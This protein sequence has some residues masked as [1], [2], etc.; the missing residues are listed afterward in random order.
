MKNAISGAA[1]FF[2]FAYLF[3]DSFKPHLRSA[4]PEVKSVYVSYQGA[5]QDAARF[6][7]LMTIALDAYGFRQAG[8]P[9]SAD[10]VIDISIN[11]AGEKEQYPVY[12][13]TLQAD[14]AL[15]GGRFYR[16]DSC[17]GIMPKVLD[18]GISVTSVAAHLKKDHPYLVRVF[19]GEAKSNENSDLLAIINQE[20]KDSGFEVV[21]EKAQAQ[22]VLK[23]VRS[24]R[25]ALYVA[26][27]RQTMALNMYSPTGL[28]DFG[29]RSSRPMLV[30]T[31]VTDKDP[32][33]SR[34]CSI[35]LDSYMERM[36]PQVD[37][38][39]LRVVLPAFKY[40]DEVNNR[41]TR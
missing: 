34:L 15:S 23:R 3:Y 32:Q 19:T 9:S 12:I 5:E 36:A 41:P 11:D 35:Y 8:A 13:T 24:Y 20:L 17:V 22:A 40:I 4:P 26:G 10:A 14:F 33:R 27:G 31:A 1:V 16:Q 18:T 2:C 37:D 7:R 39:F 25:H 29:R 30:A 38:E 21:S 28:K 6:N